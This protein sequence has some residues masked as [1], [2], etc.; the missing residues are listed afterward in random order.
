MIKICEPSTNMKWGMIKICEPS[1]NMKWGMIKICE[2]STNMKWGMI[3]ICKPS[4][5][6]KWGMIK[7]C[8]PSTNM[9]W[10]MFQSNCKRIAF[11]L[12]PRIFIWFSHLHV[13]Q[14]CRQ[15]VS[16]PILFH[17]LFIL[18]P[19]SRERNLAY[20]EHHYQYIWDMPLL[21]YSACLTRDDFT[22]QRRASGWEVFNYNWAN[23]PTSLP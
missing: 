12:C 16:I 19:A 8:E 10:G 23:L 2:P 21:F 17:A 9:K 18:S 1:T 5:N 22:R 13:Y 3:K 20:M 15:K 7:I 11:I 14:S 4:T 6:M